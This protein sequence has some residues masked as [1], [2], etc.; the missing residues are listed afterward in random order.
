MRGPCPPNALRPALNQVSDVAR[1]IEPC[2]TVKHAMIVLVPAD[3]GAKR[4]SCST[5]DTSGGEE[6]TPVAAGDL[7]IICHGDVREM[8]NGRRSALGQRRRS[9]A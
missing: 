6:T 1:A 9:V 3:A 4:F 5:R 2:N 7:F 8:G